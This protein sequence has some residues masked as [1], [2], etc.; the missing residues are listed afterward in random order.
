MPPKQQRR[1][2]CVN[3][4]GVH[5]RTVKSQCLATAKIAEGSAQI[6]TG[7]PLCISCYKRCTSSVD[8][9]S[10]GSS[11]SQ[12]DSE[13]QEMRLSSMVTTADAVTIM[14]DLKR[15]FLVESENAEKV[16]LL[17]LVPPS[18]TI[19][20]VMSFFGASQR[21]V[22]AARH[23]RETQGILQRP[24]AKKGRA[25]PAETVDRVQ[26]FYKDDSASLALPG[27]KDVRRGEPKRMLLHDLRTLFVLFDREHPGI[28]GFSKF[29]SLKPRC[30]VQAGAPGTHITCLCKRHENLKLRLDA[31]DESLHLDEIIKAS[32]CS[33]VN[34][35]CMMGNCDQCPG[36]FII[37]ELLR[38]CSLAKDDNVFEVEFQT[39]DKFMSDKT[40]LETI[41]EPKENFLDHLAD[42][43]EKIRSHEH[44]RRTQVSYMKTSQE[45][46]LDHEAI[47]QLDFAENY[48]CTL[49]NEIQEAHFCAQQATV[50]P[51]VVHY[52]DHG[53]R[54]VQ[55][56]CVIS[57]CLQHDGDFVR[58]LIPKVLHAVKRV[59]PR[60]LNVTY[61]SD[62]AGG[63]YKN[64]KMI[65]N[66]CAH[67]DDF[68]V[69]AE[70]NF[71]AAGHGKSAC[72]GVGA[73]IKH[74][75]KRATLRHGSA[76]QIGSAEQLYVWCSMNILNIEAIWLPQFEIEDIVEALKARYDSALPLRGIQKLHHFRPI[77]STEVKAKPT[78][79]SRA[80]VRFC[81]RRPTAA[82]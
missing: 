63:Q 68:G 37:A 75:A 82:R 9:D 30:C 39:W 45:M 17:T 1:V 26:S 81:V 29:A 59:V 76:A 55:A 50:H 10:H 62:N 79:M 15:Q 73:T 53:S 35:D 6:F 36:Y 72:D 67:S 49:Q 65:A 18:W 7:D 69:W 41:L 43:I 56:L 34:E 48:R 77:S 5:T 71:F 2:T 46:L 13:G 42:D 47:I 14:G 78:S 80:E 21:L 61:F 44:I 27:H 25:L 38:D 40:N 20:D 8:E 58:A 54:R 11:W 52:M 28:I 64:Y 12:D 57:D 70:W 60:L 32:V 22:C 74:M 33:T 66:L 23:V 24:L 31:L 16:R 19:K 3:P 51:V 4:F